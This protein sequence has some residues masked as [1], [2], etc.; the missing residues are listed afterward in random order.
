V[1]EDAGRHLLRVE[2]VSVVTLALAAV[3]ETYVNL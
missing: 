3:L 2:A 1:E